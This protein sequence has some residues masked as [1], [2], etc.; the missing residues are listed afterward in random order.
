MLE[1]LAPAGSPE[2]VLAAVQNGADAIYLGLDEFNARRNAKNFTQEN[3]GKTIEYCHVRG[4]KVYVT[5]NTL[6]TDRELVLIERAAKNVSRAGADALIVQD[7]GVMRALR[8]ALP[9]MPLHASTQMS[10][11]N[12]DG[13]RRAHEAG[14][15]RVI[16]ARELN[17]AHIAYIAKHAPCEIEIFGHGALCMSYSG[18]CYMSA[19]IGGRSGNRGLCAQPCRLQYTLDGVTGAHL[20]L[21]DLCLAEHISAL[22]KCGVTCLKIEGRMKRPEYTAI[23]TRVY[24]DAI[25]DGRSPGE[26]AMQ[27]LTEAFSRDGFTDG[28]LRNDHGAHMLG[29]RTEGDKQVPRFFDEVR[30]AYT[31]TE[32]QRVPVR[33]Y[34]MVEPAAPVKFAVSD[35]DGNVVRLEGA[36]PERAIHRDITQE[37]IETQLSKTGGTPYI[38]QD[39][40]TKLSP[41][42]NLPLS[43]I[44]EMRRN[45]LQELSVLRGT[46]PVHTEGI[47]RPG[48]PAPK[49]ENP[50]QLNVSLLKVDQLTDDFVDLNPSL[51]YLPLEEI[52][53][54]IKTLRPY[55]EREHIKFSAI[56]PRVIL[57]D[58]RDEV[59]KQLAELQALGISEC[60]IGNMGY[61]DLVKK[62]GI[63]TV[64]GDFG[65]NVFNG[66]ALKTLGEMGLSS[67][68]ASFELNMAQIR[69]MSKEIDLE[70]IAYGRFPVMLT[71]NCVIK[72]TKGC[73]RCDTNETPVHLSDRMGV[74][75]PVV[76]EMGCRNV[77]LNSKKL[78]LADRDADYMHIGLWGARLSFT[79]EN[80]WECREVLARYLGLGGYEPGEFTRGLYYRGVE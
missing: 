25:R 5:F 49:R 15:S 6:A 77:I 72:N 37:Q 64:R 40:Q 12:I 66:Q 38:C 2:A 73:E 57:D 45:L 11:W 14:A 59:K 22:E 16:L 26:E 71:E 78:Y 17:L 8:Q 20:S 13:V 1:L 35:L 10:V 69:D 63:Q 30:T 80:A 4:V 27:Q 70:L 18:Q 60:L 62:Q 54:N 44:N 24:A 21:K 65:F 76:K 50:P 42:L 31:K 39:V 75:F 36:I 68:T 55:M 29:V 33:F 46:P 43:E 67:A 23:A 51:I 3:I 53:G 9:E 47:F 32:R 74:A 7:L 48:A 19:A 28:Y 34:T 58:M 61:I 79:T 56:L 41:G 52:L